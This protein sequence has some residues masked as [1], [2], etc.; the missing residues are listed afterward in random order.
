MLYVPA[1]GLV[2]PL[3]LTTETPIVVESIDHEFYLSLEKLVK[4]LNSM[5]RN[6]PDKFFL[7]GQKIKSTS[8]VTGGTLL[9]YSGGLDS[10][11]LLYTHCQ[12]KPYLVTVQG[13]DISS[14]YL[15]IWHET[16]KLAIKAYKKQLSAGNIFIYFENPLEIMMLSKDFHDIIYENDWWGGI[17][18]GVTLPTL[19][20]PIVESLSISKV[21]IASGIPS[22]SSFPWSDRRE[23]Y[24]AIRFGATRVICDDYNLSRLD[25][26][27]KL[28]EIWSLGTYPELPIRSCLR[29][30]IVGK[31]K[32]NCGRCEK[33]IRTSLQLMIAGI[34]PARVGFESVLILPRILPEFMKQVTAEGGFKNIEKLLWQE[35]VQELR[36]SDAP[37][38]RSLAKILGKLLELDVQM[39]KSDKVKTAGMTHSNWLYHLYCQIPLC[40]RDYLPVYLRKAIKLLSKFE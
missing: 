20:A 18:A 19:V 27:R 33:C 17:Q 23:V 37:F 31:G 7:L 29:T 34:D 32:L 9:F 38:L 12:E 3:A 28:K 39:I 13:S 16:M 30:S 24:E 40:V 10:T 21:Y 11:L 25:K 4:I 22:S 14:K 36:K 15:P 5:Y 35:I 8:L 6:L 2:F 26:A 1:V